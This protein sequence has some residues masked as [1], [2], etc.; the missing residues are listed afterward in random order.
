TEGR[1]R[2][3]SCLQNHE[4]AG[5]ESARTGHSEELDQLGLKAIEQLIPQH[6]VYDTLATR[7]L[8]KL[9]N[10]DIN[11]RLENFDD[12]LEQAFEQDLLDERLR[13]FDV[14]LLA[15][16]LSFERDALLD[17]FGLTTLKDRYLMKN[18]DGQTIEKPQWFFMRV[19]MGIGNS[20]EE[21]VK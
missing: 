18:R 19:A 7:Q 3:R 9:I 8:P 12:Y 5:P 6:P 14:K 13:E 20:N 1:G 4:G 21:V 15:D 17:Y 11:P 16:T 2:L 10:K